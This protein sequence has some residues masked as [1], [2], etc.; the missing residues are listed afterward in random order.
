MTDIRLQIVA[1]WMYMI[2]DVLAGPES[3]SERIGGL[4]KA[5]KTTTTTFI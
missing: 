4:S 1:R 5:Q 3:H 2:K